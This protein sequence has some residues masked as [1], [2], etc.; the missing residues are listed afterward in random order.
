M[1]VNPCNGLVY[2]GP[3]TSSPGKGERAVHTKRSAPADAPRTLRVDYR[4]GFNLWQSEWV[5]IEHD[6]FARQKAELWW[7]KRSDEPVP[8]T[9]AVACEMAAT[10]AIREPKSITIK[11][12]AGNDFDR[13][14]GYEWRIADEFAEK[15]V[16]NC[17]I[18]EDEIPF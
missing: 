17:A 7:V 18:P 8:D 12:V 14:V 15:T 16:T 4:I 11:S 10:G 9:A 5:C 2:P 3:S 1:A 6:G 13:I